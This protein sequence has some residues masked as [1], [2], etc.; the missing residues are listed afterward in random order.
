MLHSST[1]SHRSLL[2]TMPAPPIPSWDTHALWRTICPHHPPEAP[3]HPAPK[4]QQPRESLF[5]SD[6]AKICS[7]STRSMCTSAPCHDCLR[8]VRV[9]PWPQ[10]AAELSGNPL[11]LQPFCKQNCTACSHWVLHDQHSPKYLEN[12]WVW[13]LCSSQGLNLCCARGR[14]S[15]NKIWDLF[16]LCFALTPGATTPLRAQVLLLLQNLIEGWSSNAFRQQLAQ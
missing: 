6:H 4:G 3:Q 5:S 7:W 15:T 13:H 12:V 11:T 9:Y 14:T 8:K 2:D 10:R 16:L 1:P